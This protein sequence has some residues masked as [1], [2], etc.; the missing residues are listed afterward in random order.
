MEEASG[1]FFPSIIARP[2]TVDPA[3]P[4]RRL[5]SYSAAMM[6]DGEYQMEDR[7]MPLLPAEILCRICSF[8]TLPTLKCARLSS[9]LLGSCTST[10]MF[11]TIYI[12]IL[13]ESIEKL[14]A[15]SASPRFALNVRAVHFESRVFRTHYT[16]DVFKLHYKGQRRFGY[17]DVPLERIFLKDA[18]QYEEISEDQWNEYY[19]AHW[20]V[21]K[22]QQKHLIQS[23]TIETVI[24]HAFQNFPKLEDI[25]L[26]QFYAFSHTNATAMPRPFF[27]KTMTKTI[28]KVLIPPH[29][30]LTPRARHPYGLLKA[31]S[32]AELKLKNLHLANLDRKFFDY[33][34]L[35]DN[36]RLRECLASVQSLRIQIPLVQSNYT[37]G[38]DPWLGNLESLIN[39]CPS[40]QELEIASMGGAFID[41]SILQRS[42]WPNIERIDLRQVIVAENDLIDLIARH[43][44][45][46]MSIILRD[47]PL[48]TRDWASITRRLN[49]NIF[50]SYLVMYGEEDFIRYEQDSTPAFKL[51][52]VGYLRQGI[53]E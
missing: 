34:I 27:S 31:A 5:M 51:Q 50:A 17:S 47:C 15:I 9:R 30:E 12:D 38:L 6:N 26:D 29:Y 14:L 48:E 33:P 24:F 7:Q 36:D 13:P 39:H 44:T 1:E 43:M 8:M 10:F 20:A 42:N 53:E 35:K 52:R 22:S 11:E 23:P 3:G 32:N 46:L 25:Y 41:T 21:Y 19:A 18:P 2:V 45:S 49:H 40:L 37:N 4:R 16:L 28:R